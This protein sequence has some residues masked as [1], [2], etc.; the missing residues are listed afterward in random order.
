[1]QSQKIGFK[2]TLFM[3][4]I[5]KYICLLALEKTKNELK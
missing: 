5:F 4:K 3:K 1:M 2:L